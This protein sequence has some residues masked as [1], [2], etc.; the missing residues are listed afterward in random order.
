MMKNLGGG[1]VGFHPGEWLV[2][3]G[4]GLGFHLRGGRFPPGESVSTGRGLGFHSGKL[5]ASYQMC[6]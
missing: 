3:I 6:H 2:S 1:V 5:P 4:R